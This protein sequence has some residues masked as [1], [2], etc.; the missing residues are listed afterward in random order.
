[1]RRAIALLIAL[2][3]LGVGT[4]VGLAVAQPVE[5]PVFGGFA[6]A[7]LAA[8]RFRSLNDVELAIRDSRNPS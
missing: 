3:L 4:L 8:W 2:I 5:D 6:L 7:S 1:M